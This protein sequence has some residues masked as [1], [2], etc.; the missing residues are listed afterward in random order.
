MK[1]LHLSALAFVIILPACDVGSHTSDPAG[2]TGADDWGM[3][4]EDTAIAPLEENSEIDHTVELIDPPEEQ[5]SGSSSLSQGES[6]SSE[7][8]SSSEASDT[9]SEEEETGDETTGDGE[10]STSDAGEETGDETGDD[11]ESTGGELKPWEVAEA[12]YAECKADESLDPIRAE[13]DAYDEM[14]RGGDFNELT[15]A[16]D[17][18][19]FRVRALFQQAAIVCRDE[20]DLWR[21]TDFDRDV[22]VCTQEESMFLNEC[23]AKYG[24]KWPRQPRHQYDDSKCEHMGSKVWNH[25]LKGWPPPKDTS[26]LPISSD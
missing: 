15:C 1:C 6:S 20:C 10:E 13:R 25:C 23:Y 22:D 18:V 17:V 16:R 3:G 7:E 4:D 19:E 21:W 5:E 26:E 9:S 11:E 14:P 24:C 12:C 2:S 8:G